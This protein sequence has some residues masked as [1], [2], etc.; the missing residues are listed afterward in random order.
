M[1]GYWRDRLLAALNSQVDFYVDLCVA[2]IQC[3]PLR[4][5]RQKD[6]RGDCGTLRSRVYAE[7]LSFLTKTLPKL[8][9]A[10]DQG[11]VSASFS[12]PREFG[13]SH[14]YSSIPAFLQAY[15]KLVFDEDGV[16]LAS[17][18]PAAVKH[19]RQVLFFAYK[20][21]LPYSSE[22]E[23]R[24]LDAFVETDRE[25][26]LG[27]DGSTDL[28]IEVAA[29]ITSR[30]FESFDPKEI[31]PRHGPGAVAT[32]EHLEEKWHFG[33]LFDCIHQVFPYYDYYV[34]GRGRELLDRPGWYRNL[35]RLD[36][37]CAKVVLVPKDSRGP[38]LISCEP[39]EFQWIQ[40]GLGRKMMAHLER[41]FFTKGVV[42]F[43]YQVINQRLA[44]EGSL[45]SDSWATLDLK[46]A[47]DRVSLELVQ[48]VFKDTPDLLRA[49]EATRTTETQLPDGRVVPLRKFA[50]MG[51]ALCFPVEA[52]VFW[53]LM[54]SA[55]IPIPYR[56]QSPNWTAVKQAGDSVF[57]YGDDIIVPETYA[58]NAM[59]ALESC[60]LLV[61]RA[62]CCITGP[63]KESCGV[64]AFKGVVVTPR[65]LRK[66]WT[67]RSSDGSAL[68]AYAS[69]ANALEQDGYAL[70]G[71]RLW[72]RIEKVHGY[73]PYGVS[74]SSFPCRLVDD[75]NEAERLNT[76]RFKTRWNVDF[77]R[78]EFFVKSV[79][80]RRCKTT[81]EG[82]H[83]LT[84]A[85]LMPSEGDP[86]DVVI[87]RSTKIKRGWAAV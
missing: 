17:A 15:F 33:R 77:Q 47:S 11:L 61:N 87:P 84:K 21:E 20:L 29:Q 42:N 44:L 70:V 51:S 76:A 78:W 79:K 48:R 9:K 37:G 64:D 2:L 55:R 50:P 6:L 25:L 31:H 54:V 60:G 59:R 68:S 80:P 18:S 13:S 30:I 75:A 58:G 39:L 86:S 40:Q 10:L 69:L 35:V 32:G 83:R 62:K 52:Y 82:W 23:S 5:S 63:F 3:D 19:L 53:V 14:G 56:G 34:V 43:T 28:L 36:H 26:R 1:R 66:L 49:L 73:M 27:S 71:R 22:D 38:R 57:V 7:G 81:L 8:G 72:E 85:L 24:V 46:D 65:R 12:M 4:V 16:L 74:T 67:D 45:L 41:N